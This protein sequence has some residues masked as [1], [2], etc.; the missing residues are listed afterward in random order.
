MPCSNETN[1]RAI[2]SGR[3]S[4]EPEGGRLPASGS[5]AQ[6]YRDGYSAKPVRY[7]DSEEYR[8]GY[9]NGTQD[10]RRA[11]NRM[12]RHFPAPAPPT[13][14]AR[15]WNNSVRRQRTPVPPA[16][17]RQGAPRGCGFMKRESDY[18]VPL[19]SQMANGLLL[20]LLSTTSPLT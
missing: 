13:D 18:S 5:Q 6:G 15:H 20:V 17:E 14:D 2:R 9:D 3:S 4:G 12:R 10:R 19:A 16:Q 1:S 7:P 8:H 11:D